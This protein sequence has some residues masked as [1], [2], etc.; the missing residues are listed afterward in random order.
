MGKDSTGGEGHE[1]LHL[2]LTIGIGV[3]GKRDNMQGRW[4][5]DLSSGGGDAIAGASPA[6]ASL[7]RIRPSSA[8][9]EQ[10]TQLVLG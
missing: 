5:I 6:R 1:H 8:S 9:G 10:S 2:E 3:E 4:R 7:T